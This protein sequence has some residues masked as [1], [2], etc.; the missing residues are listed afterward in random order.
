MS[1]KQFRIANTVPRYTIF[2]R[3]GEVVKDKSFFS[4]KNL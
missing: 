1:L 2:D 3:H 4:T